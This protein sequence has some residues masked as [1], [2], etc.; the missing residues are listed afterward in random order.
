M[1]KLSPVPAST[2]SNRAW[3]VYLA[4]NE[5]TYDFMRKDWVRTPLSPPYDGSC[6]VLSRQSKTFTLL[7]GSKQAT[8]SID[9]L[10][11]AFLEIENLITDSKPAT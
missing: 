11:P 5:C 4:I 2:P 1:E 6:N 3:F 8:I 7:I 10:K 9:R